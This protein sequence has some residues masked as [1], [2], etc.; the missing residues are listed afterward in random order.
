MRKIPLTG[1]ERH[2]S[3]VVIEYMGGGET[4]VHP[5]AIVC[6]ADTG[7]L[8]II[9]FQQET[10]STIYHDKPLHVFVAQGLLYEEP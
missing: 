3:R 8:S 1:S 2:L 5:L 10:H 4:R 9:P 6:V 7:E